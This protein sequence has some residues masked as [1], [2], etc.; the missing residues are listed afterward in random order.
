MKRYIYITLVLF[1]FT[2]FLFCQGNQ[3]DSII[4]I[5]EQLKVKG[6][7][8]LYN[9]KHELDEAWYKASTKLEKLF[10]TQDSQLINYIETNWDFINNHKDPRVI[11]TFHGTHGS[12]PFKSKYNTYKRYFKFIGMDSFNLFKAY[13]KDQSVSL[14]KNFIRDF[15]MNQLNSYISYLDSIELRFFLNDYRQP[16]LSKP[17]NTI[18]L[19][20]EYKNTI[21]LDS[22][23]HIRFIYALSQTDPPGPGDSVI[24]LE[25]ER[26]NSLNPK[27]WDIN[28]DI[29]YIQKT[30]IQP[31]YQP[32][33]YFPVVDSSEVERKKIIQNN[34]Y[35]VDSL[36]QLGYEGGAAPEVMDILEQFKSDENMQF[37]A[38]ANIKVIIF[39]S[40]SAEEKKE[41]LV[42]ADT[43]LWEPENKLYMYRGSSTD[44]GMRF[45]TF[46]NTELIQLL[47]TLSFFAT[48]PGDTNKVYGFKHNTTQ[49]HLHKVCQILGD[50]CA[51][52]AFIPD[53]T[54]QD[55]VARFID[56]LME[57]GRLDTPQL[58]SINK[59]SEAQ[60]LMIRLGRLGFPY[61]VGLIT[62]PPHPNWD[63]ICNPEEIFRQITEEEIIQ[64]VFKADAYLAQGDTTRAED[65]GT[66][67]YRFF[68]KEV[69][70]EP[71]FRRPHRPVAL[72]KDRQRW[73]DEYIWPLLVRMNHWYTRR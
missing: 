15:N 21:L 53:S 55:V 64:L 13:V 60:H 34:A 51:Y 14:W 45:D 57:F 37:A 70:V 44:D 4:D 66:D 39:D 72:T 29:D 73:A 58:I 28:R 61:F 1:N 49:V 7:Y 62:D 40:L 56:T 24:Q 23:I 17:L 12:M 30:R 54:E 19:W 59:R 46:T 16:D 48:Y 67:M 69:Y 25:V 68:S 41:Y 22:N 38:N 9:N 8:M 63:R 52:G 33:T 11:L 31:L 20:Q 71:I 27:P 2:N 5:I 65:I 3:R 36:I 32:D 10:F 47:D 50:R 43:T 42:A 6:N 26:F 18:S 35:L